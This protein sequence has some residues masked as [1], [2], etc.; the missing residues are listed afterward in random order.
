MAIISA[1][2][3]HLRT[4]WGSVEGLFVNI[5]LKAAHHP[6]SGSNSQSNQSP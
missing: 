4:V 6:E 5:I 2:F 3:C 1:P